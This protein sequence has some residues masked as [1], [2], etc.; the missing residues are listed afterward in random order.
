[1]KIFIEAQ[2]ILGKRA[3][4]G[5]YV[6]S[7]VEQVVRQDSA[8]SYTL[9][10][11]KLGLGKFKPPI[12]GVKYRLIRWL[13]SK[14]YAFLRAYLHLWLPIDVLLG[15]SPDL[16]FYP[17]FAAFPAL[18]AKPTVVV[19][20]DLSYL[21]YPEYV[22]DRIV[23]RYRRDVPVS[24][25]K[26]AHIVA[27][28]EYTKQDI[29]KSYAVARDKISV[30]SPG[31]DHSKFYPRPRGQIAAVKARYGLPAGY[32]LFLGSME[33]RKNVGGL[34]QA[35]AQLPPTLKKQFGLVIA[36][37]KGWRNQP[38]QELLDKLVAGGENIV[39]PGYIRAQDLPALHSGAALLVHPAHFEGFGIPIIEA[40][41]CGTPVIAANNSS[42][43]EA[44]GP[45]GLLVDAN[46]TND[47]SGAIA[48]VLT[49][50]QLA[51]AMVTKGYQQAQ[52]YTWEAGAKKL[53]GIFGAVNK[54]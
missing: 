32:I 9:F 27:V 13:P 48:K 20:H 34:L 30:I 10:A 41:A 5:Q 4:I 47:I 28:S 45:A 35:Y 39:Q 54:S 14:G 1:M 3:G 52:K 38:I 31:V 50:P 8:N 37:G 11:F 49:N 21:H 43:P 36:G 42:M 40:M 22:M 6:R 19:V 15:S 17:V 51:A 29:S 2:S 24:L 46:S 18:R 26:A 12:R 23:R 44:A 25:K 7:L 16:Y 53:L 33:P